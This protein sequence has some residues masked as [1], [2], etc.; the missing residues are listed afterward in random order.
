M[1]LQTVGALTAE[2]LSAIQSSSHVFAEGMVVRDFAALVT[3]LHTPYC[4]HAA[5]A[6][7]HR[8]ARTR[9]WAPCRPVQEAGHQV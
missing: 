3:A 2:D 6:P 4:S 8:G 5:G 7:S 9:C 1:T